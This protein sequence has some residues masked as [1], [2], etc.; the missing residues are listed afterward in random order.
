[1]ILKLVPYKII[2]CS[3]LILGLTTDMYG[4]GVSRHNN[5]INNMVHPILFYSGAE[6]VSCSKKD[7]KDFIIKLSFDNPV[8]SLELVESNGA[9]TDTDIEF[10]FDLPYSA[11]SSLLNDNG[12]TKISNSFLLQYR[13]SPT[14][15][16]MNISVKLEDPSDFNAYDI[17]LETI[18]VFPALVG[19]TVSPQTNKL[20]LSS[21]NQVLLQDVQWVFT[22][23]GPNRGVEYK[24]NLVKSLSSNYS[25]Q[26][27]Q[28]SEKQ[29]S[30]PDFIRIQFTISQ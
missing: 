24:I 16:N 20:R 26:Y 29:L 17:E 18:Q 1:M 23:F 8:T 21:V 27:S 13:I 30:V 2:I 6:S 25:Q 10:I 22:G 9:S 14:S 7:D 5:D 3:Y 19:N 28:L 12:P 15:S 4:Q 11:G